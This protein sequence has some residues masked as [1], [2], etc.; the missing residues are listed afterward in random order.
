MIGGY[1][2]RQR[3]YMWKDNIVASLALVDVALRSHIF[4]EAAYVD[5]GGTLRSFS[6][7]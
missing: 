6:R 1:G 2:F 3:F 4:S 5:K 7:V